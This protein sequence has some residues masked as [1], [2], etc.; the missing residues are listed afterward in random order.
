MGDL[1]KY[2]KLILDAQNKLKGVQ[3]LKRLEDNKDFKA[4]IIEGY[5]DNNLTELMLKKADPIEQDASNIAF[6]DSAIAGVGHLAFF[7][8]SMKDIGE[9]AEDEIAY[10]KDKREEYLEEMR[11]EEK[12]GNL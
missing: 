11:Y 3:A 2:D 8:Q 1:E 10:Q 9:Q 7:I 6:L 4:I 5:I 12:E